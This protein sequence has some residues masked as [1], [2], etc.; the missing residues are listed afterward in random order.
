MTHEIQKVDELSR[1]G[2]TI[3]APHER[4][5]AGKL[6]TGNIYNASIGVA[7]AD[8]L[9]YPGVDEEPHLTIEFSSPL[10]GDVTLYKD[11]TLEGGLSSG[12][13]D[14]AVTVRGIADTISVSDNQTAAQ[15]ATAIAA[16]TWT[17]WTAADS[18][19]TVVF[20]ADAVGVQTG[21]NAIDLGAVLDTYGTIE[22]TTPG[23]AAVAEV[24]TLTLFAFGGTDIAFVNNNFGSAE[25]TTSKMVS[26]TSF[27]TPGTLLTKTFIGG[28][29][30]IAPGGAVGQRV[31]FECS[32]AHPMLIRFN[33]TE[34]SNKFAANVY[35][36][37]ED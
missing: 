6:F 10:A 5:H 12:A 22:V 28:G 16:G 17:G 2:V 26:G 3:D 14:I 9:I 4:I 25:T 7:V 33:S 23:E 20:T 35:F 11:P 24:I 32:R 30:G 18:T 34:V 29:G 19:N 31:E 37:L 21:A 36:Y 8:Y 27:A 1:G 15:L 13:G